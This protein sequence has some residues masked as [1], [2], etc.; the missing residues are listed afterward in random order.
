MADLSGLRGSWRRWMGKPYSSDLRERVVAAI[1]EG[2]STG[3]A[4]RRYSVCK[5]A[6]GERARRERR[7]GSVAPAVQGKP[8]GLKLDAHADFI[9]DLIAKTPDMTLDEM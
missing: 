5:A 4:A 2:M 6:A 7:T 8:R 9:L 3:A 1:K